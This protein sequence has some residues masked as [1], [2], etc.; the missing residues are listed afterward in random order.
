VHVEPSALT[1]TSISVFRWRVAMMRRDRLGPLPAASA[2]LALTVGLCAC[3]RSAVESSRR[4]V[5]SGDRYARAGDLS[6]AALEYGNAI[7]QA[8]ASV[9]PHQRLAALAAQQHDSGAVARE[10]VTIASLMP[11]DAAA[12]MRAGDIHLAAGRIAEAEAAFE[13]A[14]RLQ[15][16]SA[17]A[18]AAAARLA[19]QL[20]RP[21]VA[22]R[23]WT[24][25][26]ECPDGDPFALA[27]FYASERRF[28][29]AER[30]LWSR[31]DAV[32]DSNAA[33][34]RLAR[35]IRAAGRVREAD[36]LLGSIARQ[37]PSNAQPW[38]V[39]AE[40]EAAEKRPE[41]AARAYEK[42]LEIDPD[43]VEALTGLTSIDLQLH[44]ADAALD[45]L[46]RQLAR[47]PDSIAL[48]LLAA[49]AAAVAG[50]AALA[51]SHYRRAIESDPSRLEAYSE[52]GALYV[53]EGQ[54]DA[55]R[56]SFGELARQRPD[57]VGAS[58]MVG[59]L[60]EAEQ[61]PSDAQSQYEAVLA[62]QPTAAVA[63]NNLAWL[64]MQQGRLDDALKYA[65]IAKAE[66][67]HAPQ[68]NDTLGWI[69]Y[70]RKQFRDALPL[71]AEAAERQ[72]ES[73]VYR[74]HL[75]A[76]QDALAESGSRK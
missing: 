24:A 57:N 72:P 13:R 19:M 25:V 18:N 64:L 41:S 51:Q 31:V 29:E 32:A 75:K 2:M 59:L 48:R 37:D 9:E 27:D 46:D 7:K 62:R 40:L 73:A 10:I 68:V 6:A 28:E 30:E 60:L 34:F 63:A 22:E 23:Y 39:R 36:D 54:L 56:A 50:R 17:A 8:P 14:V 43:S 53:R 3:S 16:A 4:F 21:A 11:N 61:R 67:R 15:P 5:A 47:R 52:L 58:T 55:A 44:R 42:A 76:I 69:Y 45:R 49:R 71:V 66:L 1:S 70:Q 33:R 20:K 74:A 26:T 38:I 12:Q 35:V 65:L